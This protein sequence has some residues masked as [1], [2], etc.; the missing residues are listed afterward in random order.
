MEVLEDG[1]C[2]SGDDGWLERAERLGQVWGSSPHEP[3]IPLRGVLFHP[4]KRTSAKFYVGSAT[5]GDVRW[6]R[7][8]RLTRI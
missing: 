3:T 8:Y 2:P 6:R 5:E 7:E 4:T 1:A